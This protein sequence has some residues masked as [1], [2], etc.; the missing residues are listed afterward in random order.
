MVADLAKA[1]RSGGLGFGV[2]L[3][4]RSDFHKTVSGG[5]AADQDKQKEYNEIYRRQ[6][7]EI[8]TKYGTMFEMWFDG[9]NVVPVNDLIDKL[10]LA[11]DTDPRRLTSAGILQAAAGYLMPKGDPSQN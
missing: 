7:S 8:L 11:L 6:L 1:C 2:Y 5:R 10:G 9:G 4:P 3:S